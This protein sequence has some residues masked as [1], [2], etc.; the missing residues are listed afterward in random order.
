MKLRTST[1]SPFVRKV[2]AVASECGLTSRIETVPTNPYAADTTLRDDNP[3][4]KVPA[5]VTDDG[6]VLIDSPVICEYLD[7]LSLGA[8]LYPAPGPERWRALRWQALGDGICD[9]GALRRQEIILRPPELRSA[10]WDARQA[11]AIA[12][13][14]DVLER[15][16]AGLSGAALCIGHIAVACAL[17]YL[18]F[19]FA[20]EAWREGRPAL[21]AWQ[22]SF[23][24]RR[25]LKE[26]E[27]RE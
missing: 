1:T 18:D 25:S 4:G 21:A 11:R 26:T 13:A 20:A 17:G 27:P 3:L 22:R 15:E 8:K 16:A 7:S 24:Q 2:L 9:A 5:L 14:L 23:A 6:L 10:D 19:R 12:A